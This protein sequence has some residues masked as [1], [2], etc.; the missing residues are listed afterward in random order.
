L[1]RYYG[2][3][4]SI[5]ALL[6]QD[7]S[8]HRVELIAHVGN[9]NPLIADARGDSFSATLEVAVDRMTRL[10]KRHSEMLTIERRRIARVRH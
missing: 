8:L 9:G 6:E 5:R 3:I 4:L 1:K 7:R 10:I 2:R